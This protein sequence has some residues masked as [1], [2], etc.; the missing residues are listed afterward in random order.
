[1]DQTYN[2]IQMIE[3]MKL[4]FWSIKRHGDVSIAIGVFADMDRLPDFDEVV[5]HPALLV[6]QKI[7]VDE[8]AI[9]PYDTICHGTQHSIS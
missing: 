9:F 4:I 8:T 6:P 5:A 2:M 1:M 7:P 3:T